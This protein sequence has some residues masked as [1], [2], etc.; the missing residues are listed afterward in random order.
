MNLKSFWLSRAPNVFEA[1]FSR[2][3]E[4]PPWRIRRNTGVTYSVVAACCNVAPY[5]DDFFASWLSQSVASSALQMVCVDD[6]STDE[7]AAIIERWSQRFPGRIRLIRQT[8]QGVSAARNAGLAEATGDWVCFADPD[9]FVAHDHLRQVDR[10]IRR[11][12]EKPLL[13]ISTRVLDFDEASGKFANAA[14]LG[15]RFR[16]RRRLLAAADL[17]SCMQLNSNSVWIDRRRLA[18][19]RLQFDQRVSPSFEG[20]HL[21]NRLLL[22]EPGTEVVFL[23]A[24]KYFH[25]KRSAGNSLSDTAKSRPGWYLDVLEHGYLDLLKAAQ[26][27]RGSV[28]GYLQRTLI[29]GV[30]PRIAELV[31]AEAST[32]VL[33]GAQRKRFVGLLRE[34]FAGVPTQAIEDYDL[35]PIDERLRTGML[36]YFKQGARSSQPRVTLRK[37]NRAK[38]LAQFSCYAAGPT[39]QIAAHT[40]DCSLPLL[41]RSSVMTEF[42]DDAFC[43]EHLFWCPLPAGKS[44]SLMVEGSTAEVTC[45][46]RS[47]GQ[48]ITLDQAAAALTAPAAAFSPPLYIRAARQ[49][50]RLSRLM[51]QYRGCWLL[52][53]RAVKAD[54]NA[55]HLY[56]HLMNNCA[57]GGKYFVLDRGSPDWERL[58]KDGFKLLANRSLSHILAMLNADFLI[59]SHVDSYVFWPMSKRY[60]GDLVRYRFVFLQHGLTMQDISRWL[61][62]KDIDLFVTS[63]PAEYQSIVA[64]TSNYKFSAAEVKLTG[65]PR[66]DA[67]LNDRPTGDAILIMPTWRRYLS[68]KKIRGAGGRERIDDFCDTRYAR[69]WRALLQSEE[70]RDLAQAGG[71]RLVFCPHPELAP[72]LKDFGIPDHV[73]AV[74][75]SRNSSYQEL[76]RSAGALI[77]DYSSVAG[78]LAYLESPVLYYQFD[79]DEIY[80]GAHVYKAGYFDYRTSGFGP[81]GETLEELL[82]HLR[83]TLAGH[84]DPVYAERRRQMFA[85]RDGR[86]CERVLE[87]IAALDRPDGLRGEAPTLAD[88]QAA[89]PFGRRE[90]VAPEM[91]PTAE[92]SG[93]AGL[94]H[95][96]SITSENSRNSD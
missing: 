56:R 83:R 8:N 92:G 67:L 22:V 30:L 73:E 33:D 18:A 50:L 54:D 19:H 15:F 82:R 32:A 51:P 3:G 66:H 86:C 5:L 13:F 29:A 27:A 10:E 47:L 43:Y 6:G 55:E 46:D 65:F 35:R 90:Q 74:D 77:T 85:Y 9:D 53:D 38:G 80:S 69:H 25:R 40:E 64:P 57:A 12:H 14:A 34:I 75:P 17:D 70:L 24:A 91:L 58:K 11:P 49:A 78:E 76:F 44:V 71:K 26:A 37:I 93:A 23:R 39:V 79:S 60:F 88:V 89:S 48:S 63:S 41:H 62:A 2:S 87:A 1:P 52:M 95:A 45:D 94:R 84:E 16:K 7:T 42:L 20:G 21:L 31:N 96:R 68:G 4:A 81:V 36:G 59:S 61:N 28:P 72:Y